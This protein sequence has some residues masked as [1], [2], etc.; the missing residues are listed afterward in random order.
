MGLKLSNV[1]AQQ[2]LKKEEFS[3]PYKWNLNLDIYTLLKN[4]T[5][6]LMLKY[7]IN[8]GGAFRFKLEGGISKSKFDGLDSLYVYRP[9][10]SNYNKFGTSL[11]Y[12][13]HKKSDRHMFF[14]GVDARYLYQYN[15]TY[16]TDTNTY[17]VGP[18][19]SN[20]FSISPFIGLNYYLSKRIA[21]SVE[22]NLSFSKA[23]IKNLQNDKKTI[24][25]KNDVKGI[26]FNPLNVINLSY[27]F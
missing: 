9:V 23:L 20:T 14:Y 18:Y 4:G 15:R 10:T 12:Q 27:H 5:P 7:S 24:V 3:I 16:Y 22:T 2:T 17:S 11:G 8:E 25:S 6:N 13:W 1:E 21:I 26:E 19:I